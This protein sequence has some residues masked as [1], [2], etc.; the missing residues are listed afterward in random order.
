M[1]RMRSDEV[2]AQLQKAFGCAPWGMA[3]ATIEAIAN[4]GHCHLRQLCNT[5]CSSA[6]C[7]YP[8]LQTVLE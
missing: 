7:G 8:L 5:C 6:S 3:R 4:K 1:S 2:L